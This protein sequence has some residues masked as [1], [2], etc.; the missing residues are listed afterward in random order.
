MLGCRGGRVRSVNSVGC[1]RAFG[2]RGTG[3]LRHRLHPCPPQHGAVQC[4]GLGRLLP[5]SASL[6]NL[7]HP[8]AP[9]PALASRCLEERPHM[10]PG[11]LLGPPGCVFWVCSPR[12]AVQRRGP[13]SL[14]PCAVHL[15]FCVGKGWDFTLGSDPGGVAPFTFFCDTGGLNPGSAH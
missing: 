7:P 1:G 8:T 13:L 11:C 2:M 9:S 14:S 5:T 10:S 15:G 12:P 4:W 3:V 6:P